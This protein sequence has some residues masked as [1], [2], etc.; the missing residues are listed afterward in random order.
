MSDK[1]V[2][3]LKELLS[4]KRAMGLYPQLRWSRSSLTTA[5]VKKHKETIGHI[6]SNKDNNFGHDRELKKCRTKPES[7]I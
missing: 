2:K 4:N 6:F 3:R 7:T 1:Q 5:Q